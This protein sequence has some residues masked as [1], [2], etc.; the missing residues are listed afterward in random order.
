MEEVFV[1]VF[2]GIFVCL[3]MLAGLRRK[4]GQAFLARVLHF[5]PAVLAIGVMLLDA[6]RFSGGMPASLLAADMLFLNA[7]TLQSVRFQSDMHKF[8]VPSLVLVAAGLARSI[9]EMYGV[10]F[11]FDDFVYMTMLSAVMLTCSVLEEIVGVLPTGRLRGVIHE[12]VIFIFMKT[13]GAQFLTVLCAAVL[14]VN[15]LAG[16]S[17]KAFYLVMSFLLAMFCLY[18]QSSL[19]SGAA[20]IR[21][22]PMSPQGSARRG[23]G[24]Q[25]RIYDE[26]RRMEMLFDRVEAYMQ[27]EKP[28]LD[29]MFTMTQL[30]TEMM[31]NKSMLSKTINDMSGKN[32]CRYV[33]A[34]RIQHAVSLMKSDSRLRVGELSLMSGFHSV[35]S[36]NMAFKLIMNDT[37]SEYMRTLSSEGL[38]TR[39]EGE[40][41]SPGAPP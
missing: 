2:P 1:Y 20:I 33:N 38:A 15:I 28:Y 32:F 4:D 21:A 11:P 3:R 34:Y 13:A 25:L 36:F 27:K 14:A 24:A 30:A 37:P 31:T 7:Y 6:L 41:L 12:H 26:S 16:P 35:A 5:I 23:G 29:D 17:A 40:R 19:A 8:S 10:R 39:K 9:L 22:M 18:L